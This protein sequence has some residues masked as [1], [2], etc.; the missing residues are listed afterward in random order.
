[1][2]EQQNTTVDS[3]NTTV[4][5]QNNTTVL[6][7]REKNFDKKLLTFLFLVMLGAMLGYLKFF[8][9]QSD[10]ILGFFITNMGA[11]SGALGNI[12]TGKIQD[13]RGQQQRST[14]PVKP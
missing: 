14:D 1:M 5:S 7:L 3:V 12:I 4:V 6:D 2:P 10:M 13:T 9:Q 8:N 11:L